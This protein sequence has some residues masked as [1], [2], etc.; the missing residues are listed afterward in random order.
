[1]ADNI[2][3]PEVNLGLNVNLDLDQSAQDASTLADQIKQMRI[4]QEAFRDVIADT[5]DRLREMTSEFQEQ[6]SL[7]QQLLDAEQSLRNL[8]DS[9]TQSLQDQVGAYREMEQSMSRLGQTMAGASMPYMGGMGGMGGM[10]M[11]GFYGGGMGG[12]Y[13]PMS[14]MMQNMGGFTSAFSST[15]AE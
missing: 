14:G 11:S 15:P 3:G 8:S 9:R 5:Q 6:L 7:R 1:M 2:L 12:F 4:D 10:G 13:N